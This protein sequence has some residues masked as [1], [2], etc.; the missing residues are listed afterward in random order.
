[1]P[2]DDGDLRDSTRH[3]LGTWA[4]P[5]CL[6]PALGAIMP[7]LAPAESYD[8]LFL[9]QYLETTYFDTPHFA[10]RAA[11]KKGERYITLRIRCYSLSYAPSS[12]RQDNEEAYALSAKTESEKFRAEVSPEHA[13]AALQGGA[14]LE[15]MLGNHL[16][17]NLLSRILELQGDDQFLPA[18]TVCTRRYAVESAKERY[19]L[20]TDVRTDTGHCLDYAVL[21]Y[22]SADEEAIPDRALSRLGLRRVR[23][24]KF[25]W[26]TRA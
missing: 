19:T 17:P 18:V 16:P 23:L 26:A 11:R 21:E 6:L 13:E 10:L 12:A 4:V 20:D 9:G 1:M 25:L 24:S 14:A 3:G 15:M 22:K 5:P 8:P 7:T 2:A